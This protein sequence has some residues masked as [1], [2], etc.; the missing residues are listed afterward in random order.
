MADE[1]PVAGTVPRYRYLWH[2]EAED[3]DRSG[4][5]DRPAAIVLSRAASGET[6]VVPITHSEPRDP[7]TAVEI[8]ADERRRIGLDGE[9]SWVILT[10]FNAFV[11][12]G[13][14]LGSIPQREPETFVYGQLSKTFFTR[15]LFQV[16][17]LIRAKRVERVG[18]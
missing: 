17:T 2:R 3:G 6:I 8:P 9:R 11:W 18:R 5:K 10:K 15:V 12:P 14:H 1:P 4:H 16:Q 13:S 7:A